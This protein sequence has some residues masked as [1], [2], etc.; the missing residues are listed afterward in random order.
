VA[1]HRY[2]VP[3]MGHAGGTNVPGALLSV[4]SPA[5]LAVLALAGLL[6]AAVGALGP[7]TWIGRT[8]TATTL[9]AE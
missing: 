1:L 2:L 6:I 3:V 4:Y 5:E 9:R 7:A 8:R